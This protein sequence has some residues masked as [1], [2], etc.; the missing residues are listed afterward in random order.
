MPFSIPSV[1]GTGPDASPT[2]YRVVEEGWYT[3]RIA[4]AHPSARFPDALEECWGDDYQR[5]AQIVTAPTSKMEERI[6]SALRWLGEATSQDNVAMRYVRVATALEA[7]VGDDDRS[8]RTATHA[9]ITATLSE[10]SAFLAG[11]NYAERRAI[12][13]A[14]R[15]HYDKRSDVVHESS[16]DLD[17]DE[18]TKFGQIVWEATRGV[19]ANL[20]DL[21]SPDDLHEW[22][23]VQRFAT[24]AGPASREPSGGNAVCLRDPHSSA[25]RRARAPTICCS[26]CTPG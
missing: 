21:Q 9:G 2:P 20:H 8:N 4:P 23:F 3:T 24:A 25:R 11:G 13:D 18:V 15:D 22:V 19:V 10:R 6:L 17:P 1:V 14:V 26:A 16:R 7:L 12:H 5:L